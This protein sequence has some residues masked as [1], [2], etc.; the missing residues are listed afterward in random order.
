VLEAKERFTA[1]LI[2]ER[3]NHWL[4]IVGPELDKYS[5]NYSYFIDQIEYCR[6]FIFKSHSYLSERFKRSCELSLQLISA[7]NIRQIFASKAKDEDITKSLKHIEEGY[8]VFKSFFKRCSVKQYRKFSNFLRFE[9]TSNHLPDLKIK[10]ALEHLGEFEHK[11]GQVLDR[12]TE[13]EA[14]MMNCHADVDYFLKHSKPLMQGQTKISGLH[15]YQER[16]NRLMEVLLHDN[17]SVSEWKSMDVRQ[18]IITS[19][20][21]DEQLYSRNQLIYDIRKLRAH[22]LVEKLP[23]SNRYRLTAYGIKVA[24]AF[25]LVRKRIYGPLHF[26]LFEDQPDKSIDMDNILER[27]YRRLD[28]QLNEIQDYLSGKQA[29]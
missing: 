1:E 11:A 10:K 25:T 21:M 15:P 16:I 7:D 8:Y 24:L 4:S 23:K 14:V 6:N 29:A 28:E 17:R 9:L 13:T 18:K 26:S 3:I 27:K 5:F 19:F 22:G 2:S 20:D 12:Y